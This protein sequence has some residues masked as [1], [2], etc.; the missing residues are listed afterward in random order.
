MLAAYRPSLPVI[1][2]IIIVEQLVAGIGSSVFDVFIMR[3]C[4]GAH[5]AT[6]FAF[7]TALRSEALTGAGSV[8]GFVL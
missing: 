7:G 2:S 6:N 5:K 4:E 3:L 8:S 1:A